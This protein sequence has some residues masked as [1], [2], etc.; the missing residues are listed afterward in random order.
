MT[1]F[2]RSVSSRSARFSARPVLQTLL[3]HLGRIA[4]LTTLSQPRRKPVLGILSARTLVIVLVLATI[5]LARGH[6]ACAQGTHSL[7]GSGVS[8][9]TITDEEITDIC[10]RKAAAG[11]NFTECFNTFQK[12]REL[13]T[14]FTPTKQARL[15]RL[16]SWWLAGA[17]DSSTPEAGPTFS[18]TL[19]SSTSTLPFLGNW[20]TILS[21]VPNA[22]T[23]A[24]ATVAYAVAL[25]RQSDCSLDEVYVLPGAGLPDAEYLTSLTEAQDYFHRARWPDDHS[26]R[27]CQ[28]LHPSGARTASHRHSACVGV[29]FGR[30]GHRRRF[31]QQ[32]AVCLGHRPHG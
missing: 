28:W 5:G 29:H 15:P 13:L 12:A 9:A 30:R 10:K 4:A 17:S 2:L 25:A 8:I 11:E 32:R 27:L 6:Q 7:A 14:Q 20:L 16:A 26:R 3:L 18:P 24:D 23:A 22:A 31:G 19:S 1:R 21:W